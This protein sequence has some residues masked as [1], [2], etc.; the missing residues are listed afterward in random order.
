MT[1]GTDV[2][3]GADVAEETHVSKMMKSDELWQ[4][5]PGRIC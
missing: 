5:F 2:I 3:E 1:E 4:S